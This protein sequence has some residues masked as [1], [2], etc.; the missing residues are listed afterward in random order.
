[1]SAELLKDVFV[2]NRDRAEVATIV[3]FIGL[4]GDIIVIFLFSKDKPRSETWLAFVCTLAIAVGV[5]GEYKFGGNAA[6]AADQLQRLSDEKIVGEQLERI[7]LEK[8]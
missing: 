6:R 3:V 2:T 1:M 7:K 5:Y 4:I 8:I